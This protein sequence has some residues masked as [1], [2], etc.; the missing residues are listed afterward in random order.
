MSV[1]PIR[2]RF[3]PSPTGPLH[4]GGL[5]TALFNYLFAKKNGGTFI[6][7][8]EDTDQSRYVESAEQYISDSLKWCG[9][10]PDEGVGATGNF[11]PYRQ[12]ERKEIY[13]EFVD[14][15]IATGD[16]YYAFD[17][18]QELDELR[19]DFEAQKRTF[20]YDSNMRGKLKNSLTLSKEEVDRMIKEGRNY[21]IRFKFPE[22]DV[23]IMQDLV[24]G[25][26]RV[27]SSTLDDKV[28]FKSDGMP[29]YHL[30]NVVDDYLMKITHV[31]R[32]E[33]WLPSLP[34][35]VSLYKAFGWTS[36]MP[37]FAHLPLILKPD[38]KGKLSKRDGDKGGFPVFPLQWKDPVSQ[39]ISSGYREAGY[40]PESCLNILAFLGWNPGTEQ[41]FFSL[42][43]LVQSFEIEKVGK[44]GAKFDPDKAKWYNHH[45]MQ[46]KDNESIANEFQLILK[47]KGIEAD[48]KLVIKV[49]AKVKERVNFVSEIWDHADFFFQSPVEF[50]EKVV[51]KSWKESSSAILNSL[52]KLLE[53]ETVFES[54]ELETSVKAAIEKNE[55]GMGAVM[56][57]WRLALVGTSKGPHLFDI[58]EILG[59]EETINRMRKA[60]E[61]LS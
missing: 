48:L 26:V 44:S 31:I 34:L 1:R 22:D 2:V 8:I 30:A 14:R 17:T 33:E 19:A 58:A 51:K 57:A 29:T 24:R 49:V 43:E 42:E 18:P 60:I 38:G 37:E 9:I 10:Q 46:V 40:F 61:V 16:A 3:A 7:R 53:S 56:N 50:D 6:L 45:Y 4:I 28:L 23:I 11:G 12:S 21:V 36:E 52:I 25:E 47:E 32:G 54:S 59:K 55:W 27:N 13:G 5:R 20:T 41:E 15:L 39:E 35:H